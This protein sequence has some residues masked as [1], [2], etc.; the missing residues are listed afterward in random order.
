[1]FKRT[2]RVCVRAFTH[3]IYLFLQLRLPWCRCLG[4]PE[5]R[6][7]LLETAV[8]FQYYLDYFD[9]EYGLKRVL[10]AYY[11]TK[12]S[13][14]SIVSAST[15]RG[16]LWACKRFHSLY[17]A[18]FGMHTTP[19]KVDTHFHLHSTLLLDLL[20]QLHNFNVS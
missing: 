17:F 4:E 10:I 16:N 8:G 14:Y 15:L 1:M 18:E 20:T 3:I 5:P 2:K 7:L 19:I 13:L 9:T 11:G 6:P 12:L